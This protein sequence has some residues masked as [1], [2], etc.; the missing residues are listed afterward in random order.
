MSKISY[1]PRGGEEGIE[2]TTDEQIEFVNQMELEF[3]DQVIPLPTLSV[4][5][6]RERLKTCT[7]HADE[8]YW[9]TE[10]GSHGW[11]CE[12]CGEVVQWG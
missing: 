12:F 11:C 2:V 7:D 4:D 8:I 5:E 10:T 6:Q 3:I 1:R 9:E